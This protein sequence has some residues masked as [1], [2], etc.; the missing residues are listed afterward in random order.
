MKQYALGILI[1]FAL[2]ISGCRTAPTDYTIALTLESIEN[3][4]MTIEIDSRRNYTLRRQNLYF[5]AHADSENIKVATG[6]LT[7]DDAAALGKLLA[8]ARLFR[9]ADAYGFDRDT[10]SDNPFDGIIYQITYTE[11]ALTKS[12]TVRLDPNLKYPTQL[13]AL[14]AFLSRYASSVGQ[15]VGS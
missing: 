2:T 13:T 3:Y 8:A 5:D 14:I 9:L 15:E 1:L 12:I 7:P 10:A 11:K 4:K 6:Q